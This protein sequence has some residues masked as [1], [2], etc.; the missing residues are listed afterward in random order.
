MYYNDHEPPHFHA[1]YAEDEATVEIA[2]LETLEGELRA[3][4]RGLVLEW[5]SL[6][7]AALAENW[8]LARRGLPLNPIEPLP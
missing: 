2:T 4:V 1:R 6:H 7:R 3:R 5:A 8:E